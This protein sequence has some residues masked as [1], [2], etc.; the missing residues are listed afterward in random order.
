MRVVGNKEGAG[1]LD[2]VGQIS[3]ECGLCMHDGRPLAAG[4]GGSGRSLDHI[5]D[6]DRLADLA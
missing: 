1:R 2:W 5:T 6:A 4:R 3:V